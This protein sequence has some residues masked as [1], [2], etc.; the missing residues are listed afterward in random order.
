MRELQPDIGELARTSFVLDHAQFPVLLRLLSAVGI[1]ITAKAWAEPARLLYAPGTTIPSSNVLVERQGPEMVC[2][3]DEGNT[4]RLRIG[5][6]CLR[7]VSDRLLYFP[8]KSSGQLRTM[9]TD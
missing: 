8:T 1:R 3:F 6:G 2:A 5:T 4:G 7:L 9:R